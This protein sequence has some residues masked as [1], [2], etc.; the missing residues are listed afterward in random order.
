MCRKLARY[1]E[2]NGR[3]EE[4]AKEE[5]WTDGRSGKERKGK[6]R[7]GERFIVVHHSFVH[8]HC[9]SCLSIKL[10]LSGDVKLGREVKHRG[11]LG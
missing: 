10:I 5:E 6:E 9:S 3:R 2:V 4:K 1:W 11:Y 7:K 8:V